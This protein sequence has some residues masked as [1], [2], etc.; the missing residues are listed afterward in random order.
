MQPS[1][2]QVRLLPKEMGGQK[3]SFGISLLRWVT[4]ETRKSHS[5]RDGPHFDFARFP[6][7]LRQ[8]QGMRETGATISQHCSRHS[9][10][11]YFCAPRDFRRLVQHQ[12]ANTVHGK[13]SNRL[14]I[15]G[16][17]LEKDNIGTSTNRSNIC[18][19]RSTGTCSIAHCNSRSSPENSVTA[20]TLLASAL[21]KKQ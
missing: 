8:L 15:T 18:S 4:V 7:L 9:S 13:S 21:I 1:L 12:W 6:L 17:C 10:Y 19:T 11:N 5:F 20:R 16:L 14:P 3:Q 2:L